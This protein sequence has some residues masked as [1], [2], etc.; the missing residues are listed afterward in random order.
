M[1]AAS[2]KSPKQ[3][4]KQSLRALSKYDD[5]ELNERYGGIHSNYKLYTNPQNYDSHM[6]TVLADFKQQQECITQEEI[7]QRKS[8]EEVMADKEYPDL[9]A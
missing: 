3:K 9:P 4:T 8:I 6:T 1:P 5:E 7:L 2:G